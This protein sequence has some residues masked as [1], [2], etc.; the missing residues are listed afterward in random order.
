MKPGAS[1]RFTA[2]A[3]ARWQSLAARE[4][5]LITL[6]VSVLAAALLWQVGLSPALAVL[7][8][9]PQQ[10]AALDVQL[11]RMLELQ[12]QARTLQAMPQLDESAQRRALEAAIKPL[13][14]SAQLSGP[15][16]RLTLTL[17][18]LSPQ[19]LAQ[20]LAAVRQNARLLPQEA[21]VQRSPVGLWDGSLILSLTGS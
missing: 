16:Q 9:A 14:A 12:A 7:R 5:Q 19:A 21:H 13:G 11:Q 4:R 1:N 2:R 6:A 15:P 8:A 3:R 18:G 10:Q 20:L 17:R